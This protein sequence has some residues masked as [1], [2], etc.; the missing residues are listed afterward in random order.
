MKTGFLK[1]V[2]TQIIPCISLLK[3]GY[4]HCIISII[5]AC[6]LIS[7]QQSESQN[8]YAYIPENDSILSCSTSFPAFSDSS[9]TEEIIDSS[10]SE[11]IVEKNVEGDINTR[12]VKPSAVVS[13]AQTLKGVPY[14]YGSTDP[15]IGFDCSGFITY[16]FNHFNIDVPRSSVDFTHVGNEVSTLETRP[17]DLI[18][19]TGTDSTIRVVGHMGIVTKNNKGDLEFIHSTSGKAYG[20]VTTPL[21]GYYKGRFVK[22]IRIFKD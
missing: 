14:K 6:S 15:A 7:C 9:I 1:T 8:D 21:N 12:D 16:V 11:K 2:S 18:L 13:F 5:I 3:S 20:V 22:V 17:G 19:F 4:M 10:I